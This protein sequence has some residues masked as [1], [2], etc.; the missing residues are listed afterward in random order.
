MNKAAAYSDV[1]LANHAKST[2]SNPA[3][4]EAFDRYRAKCIEQLQKCDPKDTELT[5][6]F[7][8]H[9]QTLSV[10]R[11]NLEIMVADGMEAEAKLD[12]E[13]KQSKF[14][15]ITDRLRA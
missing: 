7:V 13:R 3:V 1:Q 12:W 5:A 10:V 14:R 11:K 15:Q 4:D 9:L 8:R 2:L 6:I